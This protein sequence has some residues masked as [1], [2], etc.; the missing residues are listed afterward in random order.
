MK[1]LI[2]SILCFLF[3][4][5]AF[6]ILAQEDM[7]GLSRVQKVMGIEV[8][9]LSE[10]IRE[11]EVVLNE[12][13]GF[14]AAS[15]FTA[16]LVNETIST[17][18]SKF[19]KKAIEEGNKQGKEFDAIIYNSG[20]SVVAVKFTEEATL[21]NKGIGK[22]QKIDALDVYILS[23]PLQD[24]KLVNRKHSGIKAKSFLTAGLI[25]NSIEQDV[26]KMIRRI[27]SDAEFKGKKVDAVIYSAGRSGI[28]VK[29]E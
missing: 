6:P 19:V 16:G 11:Y 28:G 26:A 27:K 29:F 7:E 21:S 13:T 4:S 24:Y 10:P 5:I 2:Q 17:R 3:L 22:V 1:T 8:Y 25:N 15:F 20:K 23:E 12:G 18:A 14:S 9:F